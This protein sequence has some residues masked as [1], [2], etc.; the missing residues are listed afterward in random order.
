MPANEYKAW[1]VDAL[2]CDGPISV[3]LFA[4]PALL[5]YG[6][7]A[8][9]NGRYFRN[10]LNLVLALLCTLVVVLIAASFTEAVREQM[11]I[12]RDPYACR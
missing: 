12:E 8:A 1:G 11:R 10:R 2:D 5:I 6:A 4:I 3:F 9:V 7:G